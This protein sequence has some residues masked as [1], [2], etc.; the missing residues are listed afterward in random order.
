MGEGIIP[1]DLADDGKLP[2][3]SRPLER[4]VCQAYSSNGPFTI[5]DLRWELFRTKN[6]EGEMLPPTISSLLPHIRRSKQL[7]EN[8]H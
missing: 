8:S 6:L 7:V 1:S 2:A 4:F 5:P 3:D